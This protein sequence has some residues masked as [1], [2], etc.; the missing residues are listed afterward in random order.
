MSLLT[1]AA[2]RADRGRAERGVLRLGLALTA[3]FLLAAVA[4]VG[5]GARP[6]IDWLSLHLTLAGGATVAIGT[7]MPHFAVTLAGTDALAAR[8]RV[9]VLACLAAGGAGVL[10]GVRGGASW[11][12]VGGGVLLV[13]GIAGTGWAAFA[14]MRHGIVRRHPIVQLTYAVALVDVAVGASLAIGYVGGWAPIVESWARLK[15]AHAWLNLLGFVSLTIVATLVYLLPTVAAARIRA[16]PGLVVLVIGCVGGP[17]LVALGAVLDSRAVGLLGSFL[18]LTGGIGLAGH[19]LDV[20][21]RRGQWTTDAGWHRL[22]VGHMTAGVAWFL[23]ALVALTVGIWVDGPAPA[24]WTLGAVGVPLVGGWVLQEL[25]GS[26]THLVPSVGPGDVAAHARQ[27]R[28]LGRWAIPR[29]VA[30]NVGV[31]ITWPA[32]AAGGEAVAV[33][34]GAL[35]LSSVAIGVALLIAALR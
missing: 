11:L 21:R 1:P 14:P 30:W 2:A 15:P 8:V 5:L 34:G 23:A 32:V 3:A 4:S 28:L 10:V 29:L 17:P 24:G 7:F 35:L 20:L 9:A 22:V 6:G 25:A 27:R 18:A 33:L 12:A 26:W 19:L 13:A 16:H 31:A